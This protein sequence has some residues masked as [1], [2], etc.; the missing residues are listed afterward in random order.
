MDSLS[1]SG[2]GFAGAASG[3]TPPAQG[4]LWWRACPVS[5]RAARPGAD[6]LRSADE[7]DAHVGRRLRQRR[8]ALGISQEQL[9]SELGLTFQQVQKYEKGQNRISAGRLYKIARILSV[10]VEH[11]FEGIGGAGDADRRRNGMPDDAEISVF[12]ASPEG[13]AL[14]AGFMKISDPATR[15]RIVELVNTI[16]G[17]GV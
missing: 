5:R 9:G 1:A 15:R 6:E 2:M 12:L 10:S 11:F 4:F 3:V 7:V 17:D 8:I 13:L 14:T 16:A